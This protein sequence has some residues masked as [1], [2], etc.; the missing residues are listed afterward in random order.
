MSRV[1]F[2]G[3]VVIVTGAGRGQGRSHALALAERGA[4]VVVNDLGGGMHG[5]GQDAGPAMS[6]VAEIEALG[7]TAMADTCD[8]A[9]PA[10]GKVL[11]ERTVERFG[12]VDAIIHNAGV[13]AFTPLPEITDA[14]WDQVVSVSLDAAF[15][16]ARAAWP[17]FVE[18]GGGR[19][20]F[21]GSAA[22]LYGAAMHPHYGAAKMGLKGLSTAL[23]VEGAAAGI[24]ANTLAVGAFTRM[25]EE[26]L[27]DSPN[28]SR[29]WRENYRAELVTPAALW[30][31]HPDCG[32]TGRIFQAFGSR[33]AEVRIAET[34][35]LRKLDYTLEELRDGWATAVDPSDLKVMDDMNH[36]QT[37][38]QEAMVEMGAEP[39]VPDTFTG[40]QF[41]SVLRREPDPVDGPQPADR[42]GSAA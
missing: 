13:F 30:L 29:F 17:H 4:T 21:I 8:V 28:L 40:P 1:S 26:A 35:G 11:V 31:I 9:D 22:G 36:F 27:S 2:D 37:Y 41:A 24:R 25:A 12:R 39:Y 23:A 34:V 20:L 14:E 33:F 16:L 18:Q 32:A 42:R 10:T 7:A 5:G 15:R 3:Q 38:L 6:V 19:L